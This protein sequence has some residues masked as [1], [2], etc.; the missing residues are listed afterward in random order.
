MYTLFET[1]R[2]PFISLTELTLDLPAAESL[3]MAP[4]AH[5]W[6]MEYLKQPLPMPGAWSR[7]LLSLLSTGT[8]NRNLDGYQC[9][10]SIAFLW[11]QYRFRTLAMIGEDPNSRRIDLPIAK[12]FHNF[13]PYFGADRFNRPPTNYHAWLWHFS[14]MWIATDFNLIEAAAGRKGR[15]SAA[16][17]FD[18]LR[19][20]WMHTPAARRT[21]LH[22]SQIFSAC[23]HDAFK[24]GPATLPG[25]TVLPHVRL[26]SRLVRS[27]K[28]NLSHFDS[29][30][31]LSMR[32]L[33]YGY[34]AF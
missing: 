28:I 1:K 34:I 29:F 20:N 2:P 13:H 30:K 33:F 14:M 25:P 3:W 12:A 24:S 26:Y 10:V 8:I 4:D 21:V 32:A 27:L 7:V 18:Y 19:Q 9:N 6:A 5:S 31:G 11:F 22:A 15:E 23:K 16:Q 17:A